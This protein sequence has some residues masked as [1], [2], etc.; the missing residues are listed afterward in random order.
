MCFVLIWIF[1]LILKDNTLK[2]NRVIRI[3]DE[4]QKPCDGEWFGQN[5]VRLQ[6]SILCLLY[7]NVC[8]SGERKNFLDDVMK[9]L[10]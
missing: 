4:F 7:V 5:A 9:V 2:Q 8:C 3:D 10:G 6:E 1:L